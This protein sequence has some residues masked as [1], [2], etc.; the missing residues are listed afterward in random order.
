MFLVWSTLK[1]VRV[2]CDHHQVL[3][4]TVSAPGYESDSQASPHLSV[5]HSPLDSQLTISDCCVVTLHYRLFVE[6]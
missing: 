5:H 1:G 6:M 4:L 3:C 2:L